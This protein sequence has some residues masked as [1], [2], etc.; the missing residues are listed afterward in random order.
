MTS[1]Q[2]LIVKLYD[3]QIFDF[4][5]FFLFTPRINCIQ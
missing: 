5:N 3:M 4:G 2:L 1:F